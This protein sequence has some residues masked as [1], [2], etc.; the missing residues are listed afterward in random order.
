MAVRVAPSMDCSSQF[1]SRRTRRPRAGT[2]MASPQQLENLKNL[3]LAAQTSEHIFPAMAAC[4]ACLETGWLTSTLGYE[5]NN[6]FGQ[7][8][9]VD[10]PNPFLQV[11]LPTEEDIGGVVVNIWADFV[12]YPTKDKAFTDR[13]DLLVRLQDTFPHYKS[14]LHAPAP[15]TYIVEVSKSWSTDPDRAAK[16]LQ[17]YNAHKSIFEAS[18]MS[19]VNEG[20]D[21]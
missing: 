10:A 3:F 16:V 13:M 21:P 15:E 5:Y 17:I 19:V 6:L 11:R 12:W 2:P 8:V 20:G 9:S 1:A 18:A 14:A 4:E 7:K